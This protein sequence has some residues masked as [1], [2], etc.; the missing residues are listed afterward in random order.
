MSHWVNHPMPG[1]PQYY[2]KVWKWDFAPAGDRSATRKGW[3]LLAYV[4]NPKGPEPVLARAFLC[5]DKD[6]D[7]GRNPEKFIAKCLKE[8]FSHA[9]K[10]ETTPDRF[11]RQ[12]VLDGQIVSLCYE[13]C[14]TIFSADN[15]AADIAESAHECPPK[16]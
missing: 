10:I 9:I 8:F 11:R 16:T 14:E 4:E 5:Y 13:C 2:D 7:P 12:T 1:F 3:R 6:R 15:D